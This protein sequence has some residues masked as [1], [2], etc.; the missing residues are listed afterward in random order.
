MRR[1]NTV[2]LYFVLVLIFIYL[3]IYFIKAAISLLLMFILFKII[4]YVAKR[5]KT[6]NQKQILRNKY[7]EERTV[8]KILQREIWKGETSEQLLD[9]LGTPKDIDQKILKTKK[10]EIWKYDQQGTNRFGLK[11]TLEND[12]VVGWEKKD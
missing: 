12:I 4:Q 11:I 9:S 3:F 7:K 6:L 2:V 1:N 5:H 8:K 10:K